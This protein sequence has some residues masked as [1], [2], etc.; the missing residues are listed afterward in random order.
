MKVR[1]Q[2]AL[3]LC[4]LLQT[5]IT[6]GQTFSIPIDSVILEISV[7]S[8]RGH[9]DSLRTL[10]GNSRK[11]MEQE[12]QSADHD[13]CRDYI[14]RCFQSYF[15]Y[16]NCYLHH[17]EQ[18]RFKG[19]ANV[20]GIKKGT[21]L[22]AG[23]WVVSA[24]YDSNNNNE[25][26][27]TSPYIAPGANDN[28][29]GLAAILEMAR[30]LQHIETRSTIIFAAWDM[31]EIFTNGTGTG[32]G[33]WMDELVSSKTKTQWDQL[34]RLGKINI[35]DFKGNINFDMFGNPQQ[36]KN[37][38]PVLW[39]CYARDDQKEFTAS[40]AASVNRYI[41]SILAV[42]YG[43]LIWSDH[44]TFALKKI[45]AVENLEANYL[46]DPYYHTYSDHVYNSD[47]INFEFA[48]NVTRGGLAFLLEQVLHNKVD[49]AFTA[50]DELCLSETPHFYWIKNESSPAN[51]QIF[52]Q[53]GNIVSKINQATLNYN[54]SKDG[55]Y[56]I[57]STN[58]HGNKKQLKYMRMKE[59]LF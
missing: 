44:Q 41:P 21:D 43:R 17:F 16:N 11:V 31:E 49:W 19:L 15:G 37:D 57:V 35:K 1:Y 22:S 59:K 54:P 40:Y 23:I 55:L 8:Y 38:K 52:D 20:I 30:L 27:F 12:Q 3:V 24:H 47:N 28:G 33:K 26:N 56:L 46:H 18:D 6:Q 42:S 13:A 10:P 53:Y 39:A 32:S 50:D 4:V 2:I 25:R 29:T 7:D 51:I 14:L 36:I 5:I 34:G 48:T 45:P 9:F 58:S